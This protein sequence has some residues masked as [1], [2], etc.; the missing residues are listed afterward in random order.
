MDMDNQFKVQ[1]WSDLYGVDDYYYDT[2]QEALDAIKRLAEK[3]I[4]EYSKDN[5]VRHIELLI[6]EE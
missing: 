6:G 2:L 3:S 5:E 1:L 4:D